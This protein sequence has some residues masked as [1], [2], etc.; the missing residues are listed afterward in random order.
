MPRPRGSRASSSRTRRAA[1]CTRTRCSASC[2]SSPSRAGWA[3]ACCRCSCPRAARAA[4]RGGTR[5]TPGRSRW[6]SFTH[7]GAIFS[8]TSAGRT[9]GSGSDA[10][11]RGRACGGR[12]PDRPRIKTRPRSACACRSTSTITTSRSHSPA[13]WT[14]TRWVTAAP[15]G[16][17]HSPAARR[18]CWDPGPR[19]LPR[20]R[21]RERRRWISA[22]ASQAGW[23]ARRI[24][25]RS[26]SAAQRSRRPAGRCRPGRSSCALPNGRCGT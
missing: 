17:S 26:T 14:S 5:G 8:W 12:V 21:S 24:P 3:A 13:C 23:S 1:T 9:S 6:G 10:C 15:C 25:T 19:T 4:G 20:T 7:R 2:G 16:R 22:A 18:C 11:W